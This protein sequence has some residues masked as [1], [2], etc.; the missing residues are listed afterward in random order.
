MCHG[1]FYWGSDPK[2]EVFILKLYAELYFVHTRALKHEEHIGVGLCDDF[3]RF[4]RCK[5]E[6]YR[7][8]VCI[9]G[10]RIVT[11]ERLP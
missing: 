6:W 8:G 7:F 9:Y 2:T 4:L 1:G 5:E 3:V 11:G 10:L